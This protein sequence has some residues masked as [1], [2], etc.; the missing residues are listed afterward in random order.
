MF[1]A[2]LQYGAHTR[3]FYALGAWVVMPNHVH[4]VIVPNQPLSEIMRW[5]KFTTANRANKIIGRS[6]S[7][8]WQR[9][10]YD[11]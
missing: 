1:V 11:H 4:I 3:Q 2:A 8:F 6:E 5:L 10:Y 7:P 9:E